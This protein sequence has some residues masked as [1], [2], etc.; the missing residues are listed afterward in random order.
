MRSGTLFGES[1]TEKNDKKLQRVT[2]SF[3]DYIYDFIDM[4]AESK[5]VSHSEIVY[6][7][8]KSKIKDIEEQIEIIK[9]DPQA[10]AFDLLTK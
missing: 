4:F 8:C 6:R 1:E 10:V 5:N 9:N 7:L 3:D 2:V